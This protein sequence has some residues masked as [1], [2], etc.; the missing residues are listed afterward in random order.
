MYARCVGF[1][2]VNCIERCVVL[3]SVSCIEGM[4]SVTVS[5]LF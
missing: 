3:L 4:C 5:Q 1:T 2:A